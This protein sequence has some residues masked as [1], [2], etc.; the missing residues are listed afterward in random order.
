VK[1][2]FTK[3]SHRPDV[4]KKR[5]ADGIAEETTVMA[6]APGRRKGE[7]GKGREFVTAQDLTK[8]THLAGIASVNRR[9]SVLPNEAILPLVVCL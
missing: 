6:I 4:S 5:Q 9:Y 7:R 3:R 1:A 2:K 8:R